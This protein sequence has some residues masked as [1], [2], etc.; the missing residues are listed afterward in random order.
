MGSPLP[1][2]LS[3]PRFWGWRQWRGSLG[4]ARVRAWRGG[5]RTPSRA[6]S[7]D[8]SSSHASWGWSGERGL[9]PRG[10]LCGSGCLHDLLSDLS[11]LQLQTHLGWEDVCI[12]G[13]EGCCGLG[14]GQRTV[15]ETRGQG[16][17]RELIDS[18]EPLSPDGK[19]PWSWKSCMT[20][21]LRWS[22]VRRN[23]E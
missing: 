4:S 18:Q 20:R 11:D 12:A 3:R 2:R 5:I 19:K 17:M 23:E 13:L 22:R 7:G 21:A 1:A 8:R 10:L 9:S 6:G 16:P 14:W 15:R